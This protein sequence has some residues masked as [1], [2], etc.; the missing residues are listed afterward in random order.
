MTFLWFLIFAGAVFVAYWIWLGI[1]DAYLWNRAWLETRH[2][3]RVTVAETAGAFE[4][5]QR[6][7]G[8]PRRFGVTMESRDLRSAPMRTRDLE[9]LSD[10]LMAWSESHAHEHLLRD[11]VGDLRQH[12]ELEL[13]ARE[14]SDHE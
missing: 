11:Y 6:S 9:R 12:I 2:R 1:I 8:F 13:D 3:R 4:G 10:L 14:G 7:S 5:L